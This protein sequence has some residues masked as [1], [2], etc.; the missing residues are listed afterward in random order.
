MMKVSNGALTGNIN[1]QFLGATNEFL[2]GS[3]FWC[4]HRVCDV[5]NNGMGVR[6]QMHE[7]IGNAPFNLNL[8]TA[9][10]RKPP[11]IIFR[12]CK[13]WVSRLQN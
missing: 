5:R 1:V 9:K 7:R 13:R 3:V 11:K 6:S 2:M 4:G 10:L 8:L 12:C